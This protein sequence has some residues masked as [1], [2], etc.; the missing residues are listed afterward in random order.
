[1]N[2]DESVNEEIRKWMLAGGRPHEM[3]VAAQFSRFAHTVEQSSFYTDPDSLQAREI[4]VIASLT[5]ARDFV[6][7]VAIELHV[8]GAVKV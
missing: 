4:D 3:Q 8:R 2:A 5:Y 7:S 6:G 1:M